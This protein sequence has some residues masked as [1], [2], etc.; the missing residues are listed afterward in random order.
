MLEELFVIEAAPAAHEELQLFL[1]QQGLTKR[2]GKRMLPYH[3]VMVAA[4]AP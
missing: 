4:L 3:L 1:R 2:L